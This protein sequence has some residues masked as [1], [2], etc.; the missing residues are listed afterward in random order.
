MIYAGKDHGC[1]T[2]DFDAAIVSL[3]GWSWSN[4]R[5]VGVSGKAP[6][7]L[8]VVGLMRFFSISDIC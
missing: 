6:N 3:R 7:F 5:W 4:G 8:S 1:L 2:W